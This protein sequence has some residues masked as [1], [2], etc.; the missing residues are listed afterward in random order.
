MNLKELKDKI[1]Y[2]E[3]EVYR[4]ISGTSKFRPDQLIRVWDAD[5]NDEV[6]NYGVFDQESYH[7]TFEM[8]VDC[9]I[10]GDDFWEPDT[11]VLAIIIK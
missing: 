4:G 5:D 10:Y 8:N 6:V 11:R 3:I 7:S 1:E 2:D 9:P